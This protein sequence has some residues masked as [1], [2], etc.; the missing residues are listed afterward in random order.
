MHNWAFQIGDWGSGWQ[1]GDWAIG[2]NWLEDWNRLE[3]NRIDL[4]W[5]EYAGIC[6]FE[7]MPV[8]CRIFLSIPIYSSLF[9]L[10][11][12]YSSLF[13]PMP[14]RDKKNYATFRG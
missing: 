2:W 10:I 7:P 12:A 4:N 11:P 5:L 1:N 8:Y 6:L 3:Y 14:F 13:Q 9:Q